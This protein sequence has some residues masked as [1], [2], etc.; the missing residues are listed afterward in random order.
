MNNRFK[1][2]VGERN[3][4]IERYLI[5]LKNGNMEGILEDYIQESKLSEDTDVRGNACFLEFHKRLRDLEKQ[6][7]KS[8]N[9]QKIKELE[10]CGDEAIKHISNLKDCI[11]YHI[12]DLRSRLKQNT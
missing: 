1:A 9:E 7:Y 6:N 4:E 3:E 12:N 8:L 2:Y 10:K 5:M 11:I